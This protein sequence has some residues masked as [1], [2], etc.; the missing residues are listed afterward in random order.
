LA[1]EA[2]QTEPNNAAARVALARSLLNRGDLAR[3]DTEI[4]DLLRGVPNSAITHVLSGTLLARQNDLPAARTAFARALELAPGNTEAI[5]GLVGLDLEAKQVGAAVA[6]MDAELAKQPDRADLLTLAGQVYQQAGQGDKAEQ[7]LRRAVTVDPRFSAAYTSLALLY[8][9]QK[10]LDEARAEFEGMAK[11]DPGAV[12]PP[13]MVGVI[14][15]LQGKRDEARRWYEGV[16][17]ASNDAPVA[18]NNLAYIYAEEGSNLDVALQLATRAKQLRPDDAD[19]DDTLGWVYYKKDLPAFAVG[20]LEQSLKRK[21]DNSDILYH[22]GLTYAKVGDKVKARA[23]L[24]RALKL[25]PQLTGAAT[26]RQTLA[27]LSQ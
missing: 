5:A 23:S 21:P 25:N 18:A 14:F 15:E 3:A 19:V 4:R 27:S 9:Q 2:K 11:R 1:E 7:A 6:R 20:P 24:E 22:L 10:R 16:V 8:V 17:A 26:A 12:G 13:T